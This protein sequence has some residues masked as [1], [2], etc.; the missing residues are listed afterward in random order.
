MLDLE[1]KKLPHLR[2]FARGIA[3]KLGK[4]KTDNEGHELVEIDGPLASV[5]WLHKYLD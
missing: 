5:E 1:P 2:S 4:V 3:M